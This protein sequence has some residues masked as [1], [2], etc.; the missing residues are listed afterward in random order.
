MFY[1]TSNRLSRKPKKANLGS[2]LK[3]G[4]R[5]NTHIWRMREPETVACLTHLRK[6]S[7]A[8]VWLEGGN[9]CGSGGN[10]EGED[11]LEGSIGYHQNLAFTLT[12]T[13]SL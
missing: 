2:R 4:R 3:G 6:H 5:I 12:D 8:S 9:R 11:I 13:G 10:E 1:A 7:S